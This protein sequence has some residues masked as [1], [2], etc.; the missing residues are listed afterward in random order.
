VVL[1]INIVHIFIFICLVKKYINN[2]F[3]IRQLYKKSFAH[4]FDHMAQCVWVLKYAYFSIYE[5]NCI[6]KCVG[7]VC[8]CVISL[9]AYTFRRIFLEINIFHI[10]T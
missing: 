7:C 4:L 2:C 6:L 3:I 1:I 5:C 8:L 10:E 9:L